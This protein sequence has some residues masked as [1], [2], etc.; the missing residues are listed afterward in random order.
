MDLI[1]SNPYKKIKSSDSF[2]IKPSGQSFDRNEFCSIL[3]QQNVSNED[4]KVSFYIWNTLKM[5]HL[6]DMSDLYNS[7]FI[8]LLC[9]II[10]NRFQMMQNKY[11]FNPRKCN[12]ASTLSGSI[13]KYLSKTIISLPTNNGHVELFEKTLTGG[14]NCVNTHLSLILR[15]CYQTLKIQ[16]RTI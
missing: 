15:S 14:F 2:G 9:E 13:E 6:S 16:M 1:A 12:S 5:K 10:E 7:I 11:G 8:I 4:Y 3:K